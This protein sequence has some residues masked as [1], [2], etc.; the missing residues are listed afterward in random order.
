MKNQGCQKSSLSYNSIITARPY[1]ITASPV[2]NSIP[3]SILGDA[4]ISSSS[5]GLGGGG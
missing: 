3:V 2:V 5:R 1:Y 4:D